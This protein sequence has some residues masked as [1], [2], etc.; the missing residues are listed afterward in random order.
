MGKYG[1]YVPPTL[2]VL[3]ATP[4]AFAVSPEPPSHVSISG[5]FSSTV[6]PDQFPYALL[7][8]SLSWLN[9]IWCGPINS[10]FNVALTRVDPTQA[11][12]ISAALSMDSVCGKN[13]MSCCTFQV[14]GPD[15]SRGSVWNYSWDVP[16]G[17]VTLGEVLQVNFG[18]AP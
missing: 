3:T 4:R 7:Y 16:A 14:S 13:I 10:P 11:W 18:F 15:A 8:Y 2:A 12:R 5:T 6:S 1:L 17:A 9:L